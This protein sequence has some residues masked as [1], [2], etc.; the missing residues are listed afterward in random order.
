MGA[1]KKFDYLATSDVELALA[2]LA[3]GDQTIVGPGR[4]ILL[5]VL[6]LLVVLALSVVSGLA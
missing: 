6:A 5:L 2:S 4:R 3:M 1:I